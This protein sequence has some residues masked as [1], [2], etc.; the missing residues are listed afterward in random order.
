MNGDYSKIIEELQALRDTIAYSKIHHGRE[1]NYEA[2][3]FFAWLMINNLTFLGYAFYR[4]AG[5]QAIEAK[6]TGKI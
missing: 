1:D 4:D 5:S 3:Q 2:N 6:A